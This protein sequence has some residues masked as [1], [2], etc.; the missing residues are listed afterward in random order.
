MAEDSSQRPVDDLETLARKCFGGLGQAELAAM[1]SLGADS[2]WMDT[3]NTLPRR[4]LG[5][6]AQ[7]VGVPKR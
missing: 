7:R 1:F 5:R 6:R 4:Y 3:R 2:R